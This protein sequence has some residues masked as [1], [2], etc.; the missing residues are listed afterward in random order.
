MSLANTK[1]QLLTE[2]VNQKIALGLEHCQDSLEQALELFPLHTSFRSL[3]PRAV[4]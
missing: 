4:E 2:E 1:L 3:S